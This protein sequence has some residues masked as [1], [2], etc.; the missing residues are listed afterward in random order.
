MCVDI[1]YDMST[2]CMFSSETLRYTSHRADTITEVMTIYDAS[3]EMVVQSSA[4][5]HDWQRTGVTRTSTYVTF[6]LTDCTALS[7]LGRFG[8]R[9]LM[10]GFTSCDYL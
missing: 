10:K 3:V 8:M 5:L 2:F 1:L 4:I 9:S 6:G 7:L